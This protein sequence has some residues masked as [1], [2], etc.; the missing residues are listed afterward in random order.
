MITLK[1]VL[2]NVVHLFGNNILVYS[3]IGLPLCL[4]YASKLLSVFYCTQ[5][6]AAVLVWAAMSN[7]WLLLKPGSAVMNG[8]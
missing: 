3:A 8:T 4:R 2:V 7:M 1:P 6:V 5:M